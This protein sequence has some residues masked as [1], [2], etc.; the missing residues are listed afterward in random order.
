MPQ[1]LCE[2]RIC[3]VISDCNTIEEDFTPAAETLSIRISC[4]APHFYHFSFPPIAAGFVYLEPANSFT[5]RTKH[6]LFPTTFYIAAFSIAM[7]KGIFSGYPPVL[8]HFQPN[9]LWTQEVA[10]LIL[11]GT[12]LHYGNAAGR[13]Q[14]H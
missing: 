9:H 4:I 3:T 6:D 1:M 10:I 7:Q 8:P 12:F 11:E 5:V 2:Q 14:S 13:C